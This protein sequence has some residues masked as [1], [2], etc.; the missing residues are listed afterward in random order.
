MSF[1]VSVRD[2]WNGVM[3][4]HRNPL[5]FAPAQTAHMLMQILAWMWSA[6]F[7]ALVGSYVVF[8]F[9]VAAHA[10]LIAGAFVTLLVFRRVETIRPDED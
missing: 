7:A 10:L 6:I 9:S 4:E 8:G 3:S 2:A 5:R 1:V